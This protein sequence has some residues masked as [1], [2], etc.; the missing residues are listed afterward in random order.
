MITWSLKTRVE[1]SFSCSISYSYSNLKSPIVTMYKTRGIQLNFNQ[2]F[3]LEIVCFTSTSYDPGKDGKSQASCRLHRPENLKTKVQLWK[4]IKCFLSTLRRGHSK[5][6]NRRPFWI[7]VWGKLGQGNHVITVTSSF[8][9]TSAFQL[10]SDHTK[11]QSRCFQIPP[12]C[13]V[14]SKS[15]VSVT[16]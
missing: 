8:S 12:V 7:C 14:L 11:T 2:L 4:H 13:R 3:P 5:R 16:D 6:N 15:F 1:K 10:F 9:K